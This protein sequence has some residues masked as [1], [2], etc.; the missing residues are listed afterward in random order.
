M[1]K[2]SPCRGKRRAGP[3]AVRGPETEALRS[4]ATS[5]GSCEQWKYCRRRVLRY[6]RED[7]QEDK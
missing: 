6:V 1:E 5:E 2:R 4:G 3:K 7:E